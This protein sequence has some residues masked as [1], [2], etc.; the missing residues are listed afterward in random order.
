MDLAAMDPSQIDPSFTGMQVRALGINGAFI[1]ITVIV[2]GI[3]LYTR[4][5]LQRSMMG[6]DDCECHGADEAAA[7]LRNL[8]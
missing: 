5:L 8:G 6:W 3:R 4:L 2:M 1:G 7:S